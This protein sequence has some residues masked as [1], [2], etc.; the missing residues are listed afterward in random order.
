[1]PKNM[2]F[3]IMKA[4]QVIQSLNMKVLNERTKLHVTLKKMAK[5]HANYYLIL[6]IV[7][8]MRKKPL[9]TIIVA[10]MPHWLTM[11]KS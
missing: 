3:M 9:K 7:S 2:P 4:L 10:V 6:A 1:M 8:T 5:L 11:L